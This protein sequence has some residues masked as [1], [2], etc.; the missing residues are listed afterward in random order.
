MAEDKDVRAINFADRNAVEKFLESKKFRHC[1]NL[2]CAPVMLQHQQLYMPQCDENRFDRQGIAQAIDM[3]NTKVR[4]LSP[5]TFMHIPSWAPFISCPHDCKGY[6]NRT[7]AKAQKTVRQVARWFLGEAAVK[8]SRKKGWWEMWWGQAILLIVTGV[9]VGL[10]V[11]GI[12]RH[13]DK[14]TPPTAITQPTKQAEAQATQPT[15]TANETH[16]QGNNKKKE[17]DKIEQHGTGNGAVGGSITTGPCSNVQIGG[18]GNQ[19]QTNCVP[20]ARR[21]SDQEKAELASLSNTPLD[22]IVWAHGDDKNAWNLGQ[23]I[24]F[25]LRSAGWRIQHPECVEV[26]IGPPLEGNINVAIFLNPAEIEWIDGTQ[27]R[28]H[29]EGV[30]QLV[31]VL[32][33][34]GLSV[35]V[36]PSEKVPPKFVKLVMG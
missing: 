26:M 28:V 3:P 6:R 20:Q 24:C 29:L 17:K 32:R 8:D 15:T 21:L 33:S 36:S 5:F 1:A 7:I 22:L 19:A 34:F 27:M 12:T 4:R 16:Q 14:P 13:Y 9:I 11:W 18:S 23:D 25:A 30:G 35:V 2:R 10:A 31:N